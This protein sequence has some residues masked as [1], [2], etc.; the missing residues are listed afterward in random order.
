MNGG[1]GGDVRAQQYFPLSS[2]SQSFGVGWKQKHKDFGW[3]VGFL[4][5]HTQEGAQPRPRIMQNS[6]CW[7]KTEPASLASQEFDTVLT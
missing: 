1:G 2:D 3:A 7:A 5:P 6:W 4:Q